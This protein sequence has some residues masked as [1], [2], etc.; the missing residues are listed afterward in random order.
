MKDLL[1]H[2]CFNEE[3]KHKYARVHLPVAPKCNIQCN[4]CNRQ[5]D[6]CNESR[7]GVTS[8]VLMPF[9]AAYYFS[10]L[11]QKLNNLSVAGIAGPG[12]PFANPKET[13]ATIEL[14]EKESPD[15]IFCLSS[16]G[17]DL[18]PYIDRI[19]KLNVSDVTITINSINIDT[20]EKIYSWVRFGNRIYKGKS[21]GRLLLSRQL[22]CIRK[23][24]EKGIMVKINTVVIPG[25][26]DQD[27]EDLAREVALLGADTMNCIPMYP[28][29]GT[30]FEQIKEPSKEMMKEIKSR[31]SHY[32]KPMTHCARCRADAAGLLGHDDVE[33]M[34]MIRQFS[35][36]QIS[37]EVTKV[38]VAVATNDG[39]SVNMH[40]GE[41]SYLWIYEKT[42]NG[43]RFIEKRPTP[44][45]GRCDDK[46]IALRETALSDCQAVLVSGVGQY[47]EKVL[48]EK[49]IRVVQMNGLIDTGLDAVYKRQPIIPLYKAAPFRCGATCNGD[50]KGCG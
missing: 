45:M 14:I 2:P 36:L 9:Q 23:L 18:A 43:Y 1:T 13:L 12:D 46:W 35:A 50:K 47:P 33:A 6:C 28:T 4:Y 11:K 20:L 34:T 30:L 27:I 39:I 42:R 41:A 8:T 26:N 21:A 19:A 24:K 25:I 38:K 37:T 32:I 10:V 29:A 44:D 16:N 49:R 31:I 5:Y 15:M 40:L 17:L 48:K 22:Y 3:A 7:P